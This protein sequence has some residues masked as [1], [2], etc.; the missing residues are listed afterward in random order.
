MISPPNHLMYISSDVS[1]PL[2]IIII[3][4]I[5]MN[6]LRYVSD[7]IISGASTTAATLAHA[8]YLTRDVESL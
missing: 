7:V 3:T 8:V 2:Y 4:R 6:I 5:K 1:D